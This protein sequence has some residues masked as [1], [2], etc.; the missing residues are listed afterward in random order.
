MMWN[1]L[2]WSFMTPSKMVRMSYK[3]F[4]RKGF[5]MKKNSLQGKKRIR[6]GMILDP[7]RIIRVNLFAGDGLSDAFGRM[8]RLRGRPSKRQARRFVG[9]VL[10]EYGEFRL[11][12]FKNYGRTLPKLTHENTE[13]GGFSFSDGPCRRKMLS[14]HLATED[15]LFEL[16]FTDGRRLVGRDDFAYET[17]DLECA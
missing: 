9:H 1:I 17:E 8:S 3:T 10:R 4:N 2:P 16:T 15:A 11:L 12:A 7:K 13:F 14:V 5:Q 6:T